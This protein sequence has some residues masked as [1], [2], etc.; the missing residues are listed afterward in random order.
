MKYI[1][2][3]FISKEKREKFNNELESFFT[4]VKP[5]TSK[6]AQI[7]K[8]NNRNPD[9][10]HASIEITDEM[11]DCITNK[12]KYRMVNENVLDLLH[13]E[14][15]YTKF[16]NR[17]ATMQDEELESNLCLV[18]ELCSIFG[19]IK[20][21]EV[22]SMDECFLVYA[23]DVFKRFYVCVRI[24]I[25]AMGLLTT[26]GS[27]I[28]TLDPKTKMGTSAKFSGYCYFTCSCLRS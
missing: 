16:E 4:T 12:D 23:I 25:L 17:I 14:E 20:E 19:S 18:D 15:L 24:D 28:S 1:K 2:W 6:I 11:R 3:Q 27:K 7:V 13:D 9:H 8:D 21:E 5:S 22:T 10:Y 26:M